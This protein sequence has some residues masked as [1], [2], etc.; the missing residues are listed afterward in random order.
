MSM[1]GR[2]AVVTGGSRGIGRA[3]AAALLSRGVHVVIGA[4]KEAT[5]HEAAAEL[6]ARAPLDT[7]VVTCQ[8][9]VRRADSVRALMET[10]ADTLG[11]IDILVNNAGI[12]TFGPVAEMSSEEWDAVMATNLTGVF[13]CCGAVLPHLRRRGGGWIINISSLAGLNPFPG[14]AA[15]CASKAGLNAFSDALMQEVRHEGIR[16]SAVLPGS[17]NTRFG[18]HDGTDEWKLAPEDVATAVVDLLAYPARSLPSRIELRPSHPP[19]KG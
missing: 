14:G 13:H 8:V 15:Y 1:T 19:R 10:A 12:G 6:R 9:D 2:V 4:A 3:V 5:L 7:R 11:G 18:G 16:V 17:V